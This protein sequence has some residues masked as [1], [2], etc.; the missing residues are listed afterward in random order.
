MFRALL[1]TSFG[2]ATVVAAGVG[3]F[4]VPEASFAH[5]KSAAAGPQL[6]QLLGFTNATLVR[7]DPQ[8]LQPRDGKR[9]QVG[10]GGC[11]PRVGGTACWSI[12]PWTV[13]P[14]GKQLAVARND[15][16]SLRLVDVGHMR[17]T[18]N[19]RIDGGAIGALAWLAPRRLVAVQES[20][21]ERQRLL[22][23]DL[24]KRRVAA[25]YALGGSVER[26]AQTSQE[27]VML[28]A[29]AKAIGPA[30]IAVANRLGAVRFVR[31]ER[32]LAG[33]KVLATGSDHRVD[34]ELPGLD[35]APQSR[36]AFVVGNGAVAEID[37][38]NLMVSYATLER[39]TLLSQL[40]PAA[41]TKQESGHVREARYL[42]GNL[43]AI[44]GA[45]TEQGRTQ[46]AGLLV[47]DTRGWS[48]RMIDRGATGFEVAGD[49]LLAMGGS[50]DAVTG[51]A[52]GMGLA[53]YAFDG[54]KRFQ[55][56]DG[57]QAW[58]AEVYG[59]RA[60]VGI[61]GQDGLSIIDLPGGNVVGARAQ[62]LPWLLL[63]DG[64]GWWGR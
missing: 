23:V 3:F 14:D 41:A 19:I 20:P 15:A 39:R 51:R 38:R 9:I 13:S 63:G 2:V 8:L 25:R 34:T 4:A 57:E 5:A 64:A 12:P 36:R 59:G 42:A 30:K 52:T 35:V 29:P 10:S 62:P 31:L 45:D 60:Y 17:V 44:S 61:V 43:L 16:S 27:L 47:A 22:A 6:S 46:P 1:A 53:A 58:L 49:L 28:L 50:W 48:V 54:R 32:V 40:K 18:A 33:S 37:L 55:V 11:A 56:F 24:V 21:G 26:L 7:V